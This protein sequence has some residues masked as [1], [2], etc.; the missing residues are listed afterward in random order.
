[1]EAILIDWRR[2][3]PA[4]FTRPVPLAVGIS[5]QIREALRAE[6]QTMDRKAIGRSLH[7]WTMHTGR[8]PGTG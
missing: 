1:M 2:R 8:V 6:T 4:A 5:R 7:R 3:W